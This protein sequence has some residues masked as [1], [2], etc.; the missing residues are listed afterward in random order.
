M[1]PDSAIASGYKCSR[2]KT[3]H[4]NLVS[5]D[6]AICI[7]E[8]RLAQLRK[9]PFSIMIDESNKQYGKK[10]LVMMVRFFG[11]N[12]TEDRFLKY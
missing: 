7:R 2:T 11:N 5:D 12:S 10:F 4:L 9:R 8:E 3:N 1:F 6:V